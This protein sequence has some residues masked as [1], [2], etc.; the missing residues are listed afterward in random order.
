MSDKTSGAEALVHEKLRAAALD[1]AAVLDSVMSLMTARVALETSYSKSL[2]KL[3]STAFS[4]NGKF[5][6]IT[7]LTI[8]ALDDIFSCRS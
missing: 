1:G 2:A 5:L 7:C 4:F 3:A 8:A 6:L